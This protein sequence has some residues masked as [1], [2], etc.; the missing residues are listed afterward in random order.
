MSQRTINIGTVA[1]DGTGNSIR[2]G[3]Q[4]INENFAEVYKAYN[5]FIDVNAMV[6]SD[7]DD[8]YA[9]EGHLQIIR[10]TSKTF[11][12]FIYQSNK[13]GTESQAG[14]KSRMK[15]YG[16]PTMTLLRSID[17]FEA[18]VG[19]INAAPYMLAPRV[20]RVGDVL[21][22]TLGSQDGLYARDVTIVGD[23]PDDWTIAD[24]Y[25]MEMTMKDAG[26]NNVTV[27]V[28]PA[29]IQAHLEYTLGDTYAGY[30]DCLPI[31]RNFERPIP[32]GGNLYALLELN[33][34]FI[35]H[36]ESPNLIIVSADNGATWT[37]SHLVNYSTSSRRT[38]LE[39]S[40]VFIGNTMH[41]ISRKSNGAI[42]HNISADYGA[43]WSA[44]SNLAFSTIAT[45]PS[46]I[47][48]YK[49]D[50]TIGCVIALPLT[51]EADATTAAKRTT[52]GIYTTADFVT[53][54]EIAKIVTPSYCNYPTLYYYSNALLMVYTKGLK[55]HTDTTQYDRDTVVLA[56]IY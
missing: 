20:F 45:K 48:Y 10:G 25:I 15:I 9:H 33:G 52:V 11:L 56:R 32:N 39:S 3:G 18:G 53:F 30:V 6:L 12:I 28:T 50:D 27:D 29:N 19:I 23:D 5:S 49:H 21:R 7:D 17:I 16:Y 36:T 13:V 51:S 22:C 14:G 40:L 46:A 31:L 42:E 43:T 54:T 38:L 44:A 55:V 24:T 8:I 4:Y 34:E 35:N 26:G 41:I 37:F 47:N 1:N 2:T